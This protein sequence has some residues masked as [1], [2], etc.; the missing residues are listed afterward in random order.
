MAFVLTASA[1]A[2]PTA[3]CHRA[4]GCA[5]LPNAVT[6]AHV[7]ADG[8]RAAVGLT[9]AAAVPFELSRPALA[10]EAI[11]D[12]IAVLPTLFHLLWAERLRCD[13]DRPLT[14]HTLIWRD[15]G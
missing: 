6:V 10:A 13:M 9:E 5:A 14:D 12:P 2:M 1:S 4:V 11:G 7:P 15:R 8:G 3:G